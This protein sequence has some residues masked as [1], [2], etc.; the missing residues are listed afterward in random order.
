MVDLTTQFAIALH[1]LSLPVYVLFLVMLHR[2]RKSAD[3]K[4]EFFRMVFS[5]GVS[6]VGA[7]VLYLAGFVVVGMYTKP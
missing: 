4:S 1:V 5:L 6:D 3:L 7:I 2:Y